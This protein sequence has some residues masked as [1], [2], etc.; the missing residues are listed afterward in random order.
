MIAGAVPYPVSDTA[1]FTALVAICG[2]GR[3]A[4][5]VPS[6]SLRP[7]IDNKRGCDNPADQQN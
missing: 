6:S 4:I 2:D 7:S 5:C 1:A 3:H